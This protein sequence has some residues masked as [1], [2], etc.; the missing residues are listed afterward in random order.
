[1]RE[2]T[3]LRDRPDALGILSRADTC[4]MGSAE[5]ASG[6]DPENGGRER[7]HRRPQDALA[8]RRAASVGFSSRDQAS[9][10][11]AGSG[12]LRFDRQ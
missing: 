3:A 1:M 5:R 2:A 7:E 8:R 10:P 11:A 9:F 6:T 4:R 12:S